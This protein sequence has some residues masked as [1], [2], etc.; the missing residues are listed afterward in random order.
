MPVHKLRVA[1]AEIERADQHTKRTS[2][3]EPFY[4]EYNNINDAITV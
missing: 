1:I 4:C 3:E 2:L